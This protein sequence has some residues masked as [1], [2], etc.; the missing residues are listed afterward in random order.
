[1]VASWNMVAQ[2]NV[3][4]YGYVVFGDM[5]AQRDVMVR[6]IWGYKGIL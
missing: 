2:W 4:P 6:G 1:M 5:V 3:A